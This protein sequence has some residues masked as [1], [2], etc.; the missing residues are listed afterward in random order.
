V[1]ADWIRDI[2]PVWGS[3]VAVEDLLALYD[4]RTAAVG[5]SA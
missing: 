2:A 5:K 4:K 1:A 3:D